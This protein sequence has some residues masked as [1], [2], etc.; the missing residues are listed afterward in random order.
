[1]NLTE[2]KGK[3]FPRPIRERSEPKANQV[4]STFDREG[5]RWQHR[6]CLERDSKPPDGDAPDCARMGK[7]Y[8][9]EDEYFGGT[10]TKVARKE[11][12]DELNERERA[13]RKKRGPRRQTEGCN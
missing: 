10:R 4:Y 1:M 7:R 9:Q 8:L 12:L 5:K 6:E 2:R 11:T 13:R 3:E